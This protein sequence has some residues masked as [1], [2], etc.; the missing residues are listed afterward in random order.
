LHGKQVLQ[1][2]RKC[3]HNAEEATMRDEKRNSGRSATLEAEPESE[4]RR[5]LATEAPSRGEKATG[6]KT[7][8]SQHA[9]ST[10]EVKK[11]DEKPY[12]EEDGTKLTR[13]TVTQAFHGDIKGDGAVE[14][15]M[16]Y[17]TDGTASF[18]GLQRVDG[19]LGGRAGSFV[20]QLTG[21]FD[22]QVAS[23]AW[24]V[25]PGLSTG[26]LRGLRGDGGFTAPKGPRA[27][28]TLSYHFE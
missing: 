8:T 13:A 1:M 26:A 16:A 3:H 19:H 21:T 28:V 25:V 6:K 14:Y 27:D 9:E 15:L 4:N 12:L 2:D 7:G 23:G 10:F 24:S 17:R 20:L 18:V 5:D 22:G 11:W